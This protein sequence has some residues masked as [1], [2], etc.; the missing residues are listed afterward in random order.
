MSEQS[1]LRTE[2][3]TAEIIDGVP[4]ARTTDFNL[5][6]SRGFHEGAQEGEALAVLARLN[7]EDAAEQRAVY[8]DALVAPSLHAGKPVATFASFPGTLNMGAGTL[9]PAHQ[10]TAVTV[11][12]THRRRGIL[13]RLMSAD[14]SAA[15]A[16]G[17]PAAILTASE[18]TIYGRFGFGAVTENAKFSLK[19]ARGATMRAERTGSVLAVDPGAQEETIIRLFTEAHQGTFGSVSHSRFDIGNAMGLWEDYDAL[20]PIKN[21]RSAVHLDAAG[22]IDGF[23]SYEFSGWKS[24]TPALSIGQ[25]ITLNGA[26]RRELIGYLADHDLI[27]EITGSGPIDDV[28]RSA[29]ENIRDYKIIRTADHL[30]LRILDIPAVLTA[31]SYGSDGRISLGVRDDLLLTNGAWEIIVQDGV[32]RVHRA[33]ADKGVDATVDIRD[34]APLVMGTRSASHLLQAGLLKVHTPG[35]L[36]KLTALFA[37]PEIPYCQAA[38]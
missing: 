17:M 31:R 2:R 21:L 34:L 12:P 20:T 23:V 22:I 38:F 36:E 27:E 26:A 32:P 6:V 33:P 25:L 4:S 15:K 3:F 35:T 30:W 10:I 24:K 14:L 29:L 8:D 9:L 28:L 5:A 11:S 19:C 37:T 16:A 13:R 18:A 1:Q 7:I